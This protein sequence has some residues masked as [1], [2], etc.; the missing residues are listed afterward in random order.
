[1]RF[2]FVLSLLIVNLLQAGASRGV[3]PI[4]AVQLLNREN[5]VPLDIRGA[6]DFKSGH[7][8]NAVNIPLADLKSRASELKKYT[9]R[10]IVV[11]CA[12][13]TTSPAAVKTLTAEGFTNVYSLKG[14][15]QAWRSDDLP[16]D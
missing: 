4:Q 8:L 14:G 6:A 11:Y 10:P 15:V 13:G 12:S 3:L 2:F 1:M 9:D 16:L 7:I 5:A